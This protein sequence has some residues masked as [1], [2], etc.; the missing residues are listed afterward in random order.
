MD[1]VLIGIL[2]VFTVIILVLTIVLTVLAIFNMAA[3]SIAGDEEVMEMLEY[4]PL[5]LEG[6]QYSPDTSQAKLNQ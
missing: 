6:A 2:F 5:E 1:P 3:A 4:E